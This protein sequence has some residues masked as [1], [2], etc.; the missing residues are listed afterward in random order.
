LAI[1]PAADVIIGT[2]AIGVREVIAITINPKRIL[3]RPI[4][5]KIAH[6]SSK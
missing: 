3:I 2:R 1:A 5:D 6:D 4:V